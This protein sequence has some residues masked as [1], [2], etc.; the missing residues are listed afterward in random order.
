MK[1]DTIIG[2]NHDI[3]SF[4]DDVGA[5]AAD[6]YLKQMEGNFSL[7]LGHLVRGPFHQ[8]ER[9]ARVNLRK[10]DVL[11]VQE[12]RSAELPNTY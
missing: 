6:C 9:N 7:A 8:E 2:I 4:L 10:P 12:N 11:V 5:V 1:L 3:S